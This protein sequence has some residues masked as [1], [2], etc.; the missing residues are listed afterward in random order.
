MIPHD[1]LCLESEVLGSLRHCQRKHFPITSLENVCKYSIPP[2]CQRQ[3]ERL[4]FIFSLFYASIPYTRR[5]VQKQK[6]ILWHIIASDF[7]I[8]AEELL[9]T[10]ITTTKRMV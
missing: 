9:K 10:T 8:L 6:T 3:G 1:W 5:T 2:Q 4:D 7:G